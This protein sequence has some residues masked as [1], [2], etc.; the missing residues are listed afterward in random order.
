MIQPI[1]EN[2]IYHGMEY[3]DGDGLIDIDA[4]AQDGDLLFKITD[5]GMGMTSDVVE[6]LLTPSADSAHLES[7]SGGSGIGL[8]NVQERIQLYFG[9]EYGLTI[10]SEPDEG[11][12][13]TIRL[14]A[15][16]YE[17]EDGL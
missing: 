12:T 16:V 13:V 3:M 1:I 15:R 5:N 10:D 11:T 14:P 6:R 2:A 7:V 17:T 9:K 8:L 4:F